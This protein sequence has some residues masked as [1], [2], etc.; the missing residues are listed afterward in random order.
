MPFGFFDTTMIDFPANIDQAY[1]NG[2]RTRAGVS[3]VQLLQEIDRRLVALNTTVDPLVASLVT[4]TTESVVEGNGTAS[5]FKVERKGEYAL[6]RP[7]VGSTADW[8]LPLFDYDVSTAFTEDALEA[9]SMSKL[10]TQ[11]DGI[12]A[13]YRAA[14]RRE[15][16]RRLLDPTEWRIATNSAA[17]SPGFAGSGTGLNAFSSAYPDGTTLPNG[18]T[19]YYAANTSNA[20]ELKTV[21]KAAVARLRKWQ[22]GPFEL[23]ANETVTALITALISSDPMDG[24]IAAGSALVRPAQGSQEALVDANEYLGVLF[25]DVRVRKAIT[26]TASPNIAI[27]KSYGNLSPMNPLAWRYDEQEGR[28][29]ILRYR[30]SYP[31]S[32][33]VV[34]QKFG[35]GVN[36]R[37]ATVAIYA[38]AGASTYVAP[39]DLV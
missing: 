18:Y 22:A 1:I 21:L 16:L 33:A 4:P 38:A 17:V 23:Q 6:P 2:L 39:T 26:D 25:G 19:H 28:G 5:A 35:I 9:T 20:G 8:M 32:Q 24:F 29:A 12:L 7:Q 11:I 15:T 31:L 13:G 37:T 34:K 30:D 10:L 27:W 3:F 36:N 14:Y